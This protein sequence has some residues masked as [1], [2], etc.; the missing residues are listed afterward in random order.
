MLFKGGVP[1]KA[2]L[3]KAS[4]SFNFS[5]YHFSKMANSVCAVSSLFCP[6][7][8]FFPP[9]P[10]VKKEK[11]ETKRD[12][13]K[14]NC[15]NVI[16]G[17]FIDLMLIFFVTMMKNKRKKITTTKKM[18]A[19]VSDGDDDDDDDDDEDDEDESGCG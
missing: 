6:F 4:F 3:F 15:M 19:D 10:L 12:R 2:L 17:R 16:L 1:F 14:R 7:P 18:R 5:T 13:D 8:F 11:E 9:K